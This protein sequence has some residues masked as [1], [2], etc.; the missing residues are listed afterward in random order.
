MTDEENEFWEEVGCQIL[1]FFMGM[2]VLS[3]VLLAI[4]VL[5]E[6]C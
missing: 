2:V 4:I 1:T 3:L 6:G 5:I